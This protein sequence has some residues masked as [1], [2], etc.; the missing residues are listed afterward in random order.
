[1]GL[2][3]K[4]CAQQE[5][6]IVEKLIEIHNDRTPRI[7]PVLPLLPI[8]RRAKYGAIYDAVHSQ[9]GTWGK[10]IC[11]ALLQ[12]VNA[13]RSTQSGQGTG[14]MKSPD[15]LDG[16]LGKMNERCTYDDPDSFREFA[17]S[18]GIEVQDRMLSRW[19]RHDCVI[20]SVYTLDGQLGDAID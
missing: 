11:E 5:K 3:D 1:M 20:L 19:M 13:W 10:A 7:A 9:H 16:L 14:Q 15:S 6:A 8:K 18:M 17:A 4:Q 12:A 2:D